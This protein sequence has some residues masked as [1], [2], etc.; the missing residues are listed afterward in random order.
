MIL[1]N[2]FKKEY[3]DIKPSIDK[4]IFTTLN[5]GFHILGPSVNK[6]ENE[7]AR[8]IGATYC[9]SVANG[10]EALQIALMAVGIKPGD[11]V[12]TVSNSAVATSLAIGNLGAVPVFVDI[13]EYYHMDI[14]KIEEKI[15]KITKAIL[16]VHLYGQTADMKGILKIAKKYKLKVIEDAC[17][18]HGAEIE[19]RK[20]GTF[21]IV[22]AFSF[23]PT[24]NLGGY[25]DGGAIVTSNKE[26][27]TA[28]RK[29]RNYG[30]E[31]RYY[32][33][34]KGLNSR[35]DELQAAILSVK[36]AHL[37]RYIKK[38]NEI[39]LIYLENLKDV[40]QISLPKIRVGALHSF[41][42]F[43]IEAQNRTELMDFLVKNGVQTLIHYPLPI[44]KQICY[45]EYN[46]LVLKETEKVSKR[47]LSLPIHPYLSNKEAYRVCKLIKNFYENK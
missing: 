24:K 27:Y 44:H 37:P 35:L 1:M 17:Q 8:Y 31:K 2:N 23:Y 33:S 32:H 43:A 39:A 40:K 41:H 21:G 47:V 22:G 29:L 25:G 26:I 3:T 42:L 34:I 9:V 6:F 28:A 11:E 14:S 18:A 38:R 15:T 16:P 7:F 13:D 30:S 45:T 19:G 10:L 36:L 4:A 12:L 20:A 46:N 5:K